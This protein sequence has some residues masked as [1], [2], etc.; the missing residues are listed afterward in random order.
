MVLKLNT[1][2]NSGNETVMIKNIIGQLIKKYS[3]L[4]IFLLLPLVV[5]SFTVKGDTKKIFT[6]RV[7]FSIKDS[8]DELITL[9]R[10]LLVKTPEG[11]DI[12][13]TLELL[14]QSKR[15]S[16]IEMIK[17]EEEVVLK[18]IPNYLIK[19]ITI[20]GNYPI[21]KSKIFK[22]MTI[23]SGM[24][25]QVE[26]VE[27]QK[28][29]IQNFFKS[30]SFLAAVVTVDY[31]KKENYY[32]LKYFI[33][34]GSYQVLE[35]ISFRGNDNFSDFRL[36]SKT[37]SWINSLF[38]GESS[39][40]LKSKLKEDIATLLEFYYSKGYY[41][42][43]IDYMTDADSNDLKVNLQIIVKEGPLYEIEFMGND[44]F[45]DF[46]LEKELVLKERGNIGNNGVI[47]SKNKIIKKYKDAGFRDIKV[48]TENIVENKTKKIIFHIT[49]NK[50]YFTGK[51]TISGNKIIS[52]EEINKNILSAP[53]TFFSSGVFC[54]QIFTNDLNAL[55]NLYI[56]KGYRN[57]LITDSLTVVGEESN[58][59][60][61]EINIEENKPLLIRNVEIM[62]VTEEEEREIVS[63]VKNRKGEIFHDYQL[64]KDINKI[65][66][67]ISEKG[68]PLV[69]IDKT[70]SGLDSVDIKYTI[71]R[72]KKMFQGKTF[73]SGNFQ[74]KEKL[75][76]EQL[77]FKEGAPFS[78]K[79]L[80]L[81]QKELR[82]M[83][84]FNSVKF[85]GLGLL[86]KRDKITVIAELEE[87]KPYYYAVGSG[88]ESFSGFFANLEFGNKNIGGY[89][90]NMT[91]KTELTQT[92]YSGELTLMG[93]KIFGKK[94][95]PTLKGYFAK[96][97]EFNLD[98]TITKFGIISG[99]GKNITKKIKA[100]VNLNFESRERKNGE[101]D[102]RVFTMLS[103]YA[104]YD[105]RDYYLRPEEG[106]FSGIT[107]DLSRGLT[108]KSDN[109]FKYSAFFRYYFKISSKT[110]IAFLAKNG[111]IIKMDSDQIA[112][113]RI[114]YLGGT[115]SIRGFEENML[116]FNNDKEAVGGLSYYNF[117]VETRYE[118]IDNFEFNIFFDTGNIN[119]FFS[120]AIAEGVRSSVGSGLR[121]LTPIGPIGLAYGYKLKKEKSESRGRIHFSIGYTF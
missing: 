3:V 70:I 20:E 39:R 96:R 54:D 107:I 2:M 27:E 104:S 85:T 98:Y 56:S 37:S 18:L 106:I 55:K 53:P 78:L 63:I 31:Q 1:N 101:T 81:S 89:N 91:L 47:I 119:N 90:K 28:A 60:N 9:A 33:K 12:T 43:D 100:G 17:K 82:N 120:T 69:K 88:Y 117:A 111:Q 66:S 109:F 51:I 25:F 46:S 87:K 48:K 15:F 61:I 64:Y 24:F 41:E 22:A 16:S 34:P 67:V 99:I 62:G 112:E 13:T 76:R 110:I 94:L 80:L 26:K 57:T 42:A 116:Y 97:D 75:L 102:N 38:W 83:A 108:Q 103:P 114:F 52:R 19:N 86:E 79:N 7:S 10:E 65:K 72:G 73:F 95:K 74:T 23:H 84:L 32:D 121:Y 36:K 8:D 45:Y 59:V 44:Y 5:S 118:F 71:K 93:Q 4:I 21:L 105:S 92:G 11:I 58:I 113:D 29:I 115:S 30:E 35:K 6:D 50:Q 49:E 40:Y 14:R 68:Y 77:K